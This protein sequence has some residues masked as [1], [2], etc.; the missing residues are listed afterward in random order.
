MP[1]VVKNEKDS[2]PPNSP[3]AQVLR[4]FFTSPPTYESNVK[5]TVGMSNGI[6]RNMFQK[7]DVGG[8]HPAFAAE[9]MT[10]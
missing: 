9:S 6:I 3:M 5:A 8:A 10:C 7:L 1:I 2:E 4:E